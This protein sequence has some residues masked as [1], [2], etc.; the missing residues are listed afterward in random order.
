VGAAALVGAIFAIPFVLVGSRFRATSWSKK[1]RIFAVAVFV[2]PTLPFLLLDPRIPEVGNQVVNWLLFGALLPL[3]ALA[4]GAL[5]DA[6]DPRSSAR[7]VLH[8]I[9]A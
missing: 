8:T 5:L 3:F 6:L 2:F 7:D 4:L 9:D 1:S